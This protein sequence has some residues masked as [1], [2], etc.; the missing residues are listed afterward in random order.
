MCEL[1]ETDRDYFAKMMAHLP[2]ENRDQ[3]QR[4]L[5]R[6]EVHRD[7]GG[8]LEREVNPDPDDV[9]NGGRGDPALVCFSDG[10][11][12]YSIKLE[13]G[14]VLASGLGPVRAFRGGRELVKVWVRPDDDGGV[15]AGAIFGE[16]EIVSSI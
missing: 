10:M 2:P 16:V 9:G 13:D 7:G 3:W 5:D 11:T 14:M 8:W 4:V 15:L 6:G 12:M 1:T